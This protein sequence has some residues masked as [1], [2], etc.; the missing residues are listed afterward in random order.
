MDTISAAK[1]KNGRFY[2]H[3]LDKHAFVWGDFNARLGGSIYYFHVPW[4]FWRR[5][6]KNEFEIRPDFGYAV[7]PSKRQEK[8]FWSICVSVCRSVRLAVAF[9]ANPHGRKG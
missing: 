9:V 8:W 6:K 2:S 7:R 3:A 1:N 4:K 5:A